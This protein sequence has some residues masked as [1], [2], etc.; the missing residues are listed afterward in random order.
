M[1]MMRCECSQRSRKSLIPGRTF[2]WRR[3]STPRGDYAPWA[4]FPCRSATPISSR[5]SPSTVSAWTPPHPR[6]AHEGLRR[7]LRALEGQKRDCLRPADSLCN[8]APA[9]HRQ[10]TAKYALFF[11]DD[12]ERLV[13][14]RS[15]V[16]DQCF[17]DRAGTLVSRHMNEIGGNDS[18]LAGFEERAPFSFDV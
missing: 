8:A 12:N 18:G 14:C 2:L 4:T 13:L 9:A 16:D 5:Q 7:F 10:T 1:A 15:A 17:P 6:F 11:N 3:A